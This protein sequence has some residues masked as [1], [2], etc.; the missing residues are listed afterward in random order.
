ML[1]VKEYGR[2]AGAIGR[3]CLYVL[4][5]G[6]SS[7]W[8][9]AL[10][11]EYVLGPYICGVIVTGLIRVL[12]GTH[13]DWKFNSLRGLG[14]GIASYADMCVCVCGKRDSLFEID[15]YTFFC[16]PLPSASSL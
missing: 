11:Y 10:W 4:R 6:G 12:Y 8:K 14:G 15:G 2:T 16:H 5:M 7:P 9:T 1:F 3:A 13:E